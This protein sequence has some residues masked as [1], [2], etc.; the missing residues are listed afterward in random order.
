MRRWEGTLRNPP[1]FRQSR[2]NDRPSLST[3]TDNQTMHCVKKIFALQVRSIPAPLHLLM[4]VFR[5]FRPS[6][7]YV[8]FPLRFAKRCLSLSHPKRMRY[9]NGHQSSQVEHLSAIAILMLLS[10]PADD[11]VGHL[12][13]VPLSF[14]L[15][16]RDFGLAVMCDARIALC[17][18]VIT[19]GAHFFL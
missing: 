13:S 16:V 14:V 11:N 3:F 7:S 5:P 1:T 4:A 19:F 2:E 12:T 15:R 17:T 10:P 6:S 8:S 18:T 9:Y